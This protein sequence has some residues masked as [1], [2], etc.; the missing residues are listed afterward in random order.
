MFYF[1][2][3]K[4]GLSHINTEYQRAQGTQPGWVVSFVQNKKK[5]KKLNQNGNYSAQNNKL[6]QK[7]NCWSD[8]K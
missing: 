7:D 4:I 2:A 1:L 3:R 5:K 8:E 6:I